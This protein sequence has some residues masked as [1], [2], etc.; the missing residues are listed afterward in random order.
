MMGRTTNENRS[1]HL[2]DGVVRGLMAES[3]FP[4]TGLVT[5]AY[6]TRALLPEGYGW[7]TLVASFVGWVEWTVATVFSR[8]ALKLVGEAGED[9]QRIGSALVR[10]HL[11]LGCGAMLLVM[12]L[13]SPLGRVFGDES[14]AWWLGLM[15]LEIPV[16]SVAHAHRSVLTGRGGYRQ[17]AVA[18]VWR[19][20]SR[21]V[22]I[23][24]LVELGMSV[25]GA[26]L[27][28]LAATVIELV[29][30][31]RYCSIPWRVA[32]P[33]SVR[34][35]LGY[36]VP[37]FVASACLRLFDVQMV[38]M[39]KA[40]GGSAQE[41][42]WL[43]AAVN[44]AILPR[45]LSMT[46]VPMLTATL[47]HAVR[48]GEHERARALTRDALRVVWWMLPLVGLT[49]GA[50]RE[51]AGL[52]FGARFV[53]AGPLLGWL[54]WGAIGTVVFNVVTGV[55]TAAGYPR[56]T[57]GYAVALV[58]AGIGLGLWWVPSWGALGAAMAWSISAWFGA[59]LA[60]WT[61][62]RVW[63]VEMPVT[64][65]GRCAIVGVAV[66]WVAREWATPGGWVVLKMMLLATGAV[67]GLVI[68][69][70]WGW[71]EWNL[72]RSLMAWNRS[73]PS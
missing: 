13:A 69:R 48:D 2:A 56:A 51:I 10:W 49:A 40:C 11:W 64:A 15:A 46:F 66:W 3:L 73:A 5:A 47:T 12:G 9:W 26:I 37:L 1:R 19:W 18:S 62:H 23:V 36:A 44:V 31:R 21:L 68:V 25:S 42:G 55:L 39:L 43:G 52:L 28:N 50:G 20:L 32:N 29:V 70:E 53:E 54:M 35:V 8:A 63:K 34:E 71:R 16:F 14:V 45:L 33:V 65:L 24:G 4:L 41:V 57:V 22:L 67:F 27:G 61:V 38:L 59:G 6:L 58:V 17:R 7:F 60:L 72:A 30:T